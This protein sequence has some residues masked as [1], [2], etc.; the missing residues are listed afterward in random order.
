MVLGV[1][2]FKHFGVFTLEGWNMYS[3][4]IVK[5]LHVYETVHCH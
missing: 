5:K 3:V 2:V 4:W 1:P